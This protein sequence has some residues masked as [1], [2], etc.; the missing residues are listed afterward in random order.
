MS[1]KDKDT[2]EQGRKSEHVAAESEEL[3][4]YPETVVLG[5][6]FLCAQ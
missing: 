6:Y 2:N 5:S 4:R 1:I 3:E